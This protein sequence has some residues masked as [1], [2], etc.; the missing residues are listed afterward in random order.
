M[1]TPSTVIARLGDAWP[2]I[3]NRE[4]LTSARDTA[5]AACAEPARTVDSSAANINN[6]NTA[7]DLRRAMSISFVPHCHSSMP[8]RAVIGRADLRATLRSALR[9]LPVYHG[10]ST[11]AAAVTLYCAED[12]ESATRRS[13]VF[14]TMSVQKPYL[15]TAISMTMPSRP[16]G[17]P[18]TETDELAEAI[19]AVAPLYPGASSADILRAS[20]ISESRPSASDKVGIELLY[21]TTPV[22]PHLPTSPHE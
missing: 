20:S 7:K 18:L 17:P 10:R 14:S 21:A 9:G 11:R 12:V 19:D 15:L 2:S 16:P 6:T 1:F 5:T 8:C 13:S 4:P 3:R 22:P